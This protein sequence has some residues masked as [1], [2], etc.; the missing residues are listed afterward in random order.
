MD[1]SVFLVTGGSRGIGAA[2]AIAAARAGYRVLLSYASAADRA[3]QVVAGIRAEGGLAQAVL[4][5]IADAEDVAALFAAADAMG[6]LKVLACSGGITGAPSQ[7]A[8][9]E[10]E[11]LSRVVDVNLVGAMLCAREAVRRMSTDSGGTGGAIVFLSSRAT[12]YGSPNEHV[13]Y[14]ASKGGI[15]A[16]TTGLAREVGGQGIR[17]NA[18]S[19]GPIDTEM[20][21][22]QKRA[23]ATALSPV[24]RIGTP[25][26]AAAAVMFLASDAAS[27]ITGANLAVSGGR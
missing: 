2:I 9:V 11:T 25:E 24:G 17:V 22:A 5:D 15:D 16:L 26:E 10:P 12:A 27:F 8:D 6:P 7:L 4:A 1:G 20:L 13:W 18:V 21:S 3:A 14:A 23:A 19:P